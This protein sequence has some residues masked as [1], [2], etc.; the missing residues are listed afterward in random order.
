[1]EIVERSLFMRYVAGITPWLVLWS[2]TTAWGQYGLSG[3]PELLWTQQAAGQGTGYASRAALLAEPVAYDVSPAQT[4]P[5]TQTVAPAGRPSLPTSSFSKSAP[6]TSGPSE[7]YG[8]E[9][10][11]LTYIPAIAHPALRSEMPV[12]GTGPLLQPA[13]PQMQPVQPRMQPVQP[14]NIRPQYIYAPAVPNPA[15]RSAAPQGAYVPAPIRPPYAT[16]TSLP[17]RLPMPAMSDRPAVS[18]GRAAIA[19]T[20]AYLPTPASNSN[21][22]DPAPREEA[23]KATAAGDCGC[24]ANGTTSGTCGTDS[25]DTSGCG[26]CGRDPWY[27][28]VQGLFMFRDGYHF[29]TFS[30]LNSDAGQAH[31]TPQEIVPEY[32]WGGEVRLGRRFLCDRWAMEGV[33]WG[34]SPFESR[35]LTAA[36]ASN[37]NLG[38]N[39]SQVQL[40]NTGTNAWVN[41]DTAFLTQANQQQYSYRSEVHNAEVNL[42]TGSL[43]GRQSE[44]PWDLQFSIGARFFRFDDRLWIDSA[45]GTNDQG[46]ARTFGN[47]TSADDPW[48]TRISERVTNDLWGGQVGF[49]GAWYVHPCIRFFAGTKFGVYNDHMVGEFDVRQW[50][51]LGARMTNTNGA[52]VGAYPTH[53][54]RNDIALLSQVDVG[55]DWVFAANWSARFGYRL[56]SVSGVALADEQISYQLHDLTSAT[57][58][59]HTGDLILHGAF[60]GI[61][62]NF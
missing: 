5:V 10:P 21:S 16:G 31:L 59:Q 42:V 45:Y 6:V 52:V 2:A 54:V 8:P 44:M 37:V 43:G 49:Y 22:Y 11:R 19:Q 36:S 9:Q 48:V 60:V 56:V 61:N 32:Q 1:M 50:N 20:P 7:V 38:S 58:I 15:V 14:Q 26:D 62:W 41:G 18:I 12:E 25:C 46:A 3:S 30:Y 13:Q 23:P 17:Q 57:Q 39:V 34:T 4:L 29:S 33:Y 27:A 35:M 55:V 53:A 47:I 51:G 24:S 40:W 28:S